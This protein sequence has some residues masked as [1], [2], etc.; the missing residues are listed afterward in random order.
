MRHILGYIVVYFSIIFGSIFISKTFKKKLESC[1]AIDIFI[2]MILLYIFGLINNLYLCT[3]LINVIPIILGIIAI[4]K[5]RKEKDF[6][7]SIL[8]NGLM[9]FTILYFI[10][11]IFTFYRI[12]NIWDEYSYWSTIS[13]KM[14]YSNKLLNSEMLGLYPPFPTVLQYYFTKTIGTYSQGIELFANY[15]LGFSLLLP[16][17]EK[18]KNNSKISNI[19]IGIIIICI[20]TIFTYMIFYQSIYVDSILGLVIGYILYQLYNEENK[21]F[22]YFSLT[23]AF[24]V[25]TLTKATGFYIAFILLVA[26]CITNFAKYVKDRKKIKILENIKTNQKSIIA[27]LGITI[28]I[29]VVFL[30]WNLYIKDYKEYKDLIEKEYQE[31]SE[32]Y[33]SISDALKTILTTMFGTKNEKNTERN[34]SNMEL[35]Y[36]FYEKKAINQPIKISL[37]AFF[38]LY[39]IGSIVLYKYG[40]KNKQKEKFKKIQISIVI[41]LILYVFFLQLAYLT[42]F[43]ISEAL[44]HS[45]LERYINTFFLGMTVLLISVVIDKIEEN[46]TNIKSKYIIL[47]LII[48]IISPLN[49]ITNATITSGSANAIERGKLIQVST[50]AKIIK[51][52]LNK[53]DRIYVIN[54]ESNEKASTWQLKYYLIPEIEIKTTRKFDKE[55]EKIYENG[56]FLENW[57]NILYNDYDYVYIYVT[58]EYFNEL[59]K[60]LFENEKIEEKT[61]YKIEK[62]NNNIK[63]IKY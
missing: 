58:D 56:E 59:A 26:I 61:I 24:I 52:K 49:I 39:I 4:I 37:M 29:L 47:T 55:L 44:E 25:L 8:T 11:I 7:E 13:K 36:A 31:K 14:Y 17:F 1:F 3:I 34:V 27:L 41:S 19:C 51:E 30:S 10:F 48:L 63:L 33:L 20:P 18:V 22:L 60:E 57:K 2:K 45:S 15:I 9:F 6:K 46:V 50:Q 35:F 40:I 38:I 42:K 43:S 23:L 54:Q 21:K 12:M 62:Q 5:S 53:E 16:L 28:I 32:E